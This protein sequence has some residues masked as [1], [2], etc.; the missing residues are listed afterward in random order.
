MDDDPQRPW[1]KSLLR[2]MDYIVARLLARLAQSRDID[3]F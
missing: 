2:R 3:L 1:G